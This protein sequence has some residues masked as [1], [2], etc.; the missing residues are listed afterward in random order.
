MRILGVSGGL[1]SPSKTHGL[2]NAIVQRLAQAAQVDAEII[3]LAQ[4]ATGFGAVLYREQLSA[5]QEALLQR[6]EQAD[7][8]VVAT[9]VYRASYPGLFKHIFDLIER[10][11]LQGKAVILAANGGSTHHALVIDSHLRPLLS[12]LGAY[13]V[14]TG[15]YS[16]ASDF[17][18]Y[19]LSDKT[20]LARIDIAIGEVLRLQSGLAAA[21][22]A[23]AHIEPAH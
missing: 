8:L 23:V 17:S 1:S 4:V 6:I 12:S 13:T 16:Q 22:K 14:P 10:E 2:V 20:L 15:I 19:E 21:K 9:P 5:E 11:G 18:G 3:D 7:V